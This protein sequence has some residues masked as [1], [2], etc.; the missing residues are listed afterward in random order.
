MSN[1]K[2]DLTYQDREVQALFSKMQSKGRHTEPAMRDIGEAMF[3]STDKR[4]RSQVDPEGSAWA[5]LSP[6]TLKHKRNKKILTERG[7]LRG[8]MA[9]Q[10]STNRVVWGTNSPYGAIHQNGGEIKKKAR[11]QTLAFNGR[12]RFTS[13]KAASKRKRGAIGVAFTS[14]GAHSVTIPARPYLGVS[15][16]DREIILRILRRHVRPTP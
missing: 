5:P 13:R 8:S 9:Y 3:I 7:Y 12:G 11:S 16:K 2:I 4:F 15:R 14:I 10:A 6:R 1:F